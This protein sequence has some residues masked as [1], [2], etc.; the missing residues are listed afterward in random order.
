M[1]ITGT[2]FEMNQL[3]PVCNVG[4]PSVLICF[5][6]PDGYHRVK[7]VEGVKLNCFSKGLNDVIPNLNSN[8]GCF[9]FPFGKNSDFERSYFCFTGCHLDIKLSILIFERIHPT[10]YTLMVY[11]LLRRT[12]P[13]WRHARLT[14]GKSWTY[15]L[16][17]IASSGGR[18]SSHFLFILQHSGRVTP[19]HVSC[20]RLFFG[21]RPFSTVS[22]QKQT[23][24]RMFPSLFLLDFKYPQNHI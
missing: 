11:T 19:G 1:Y 7:P 12:L 22:I 4:L 13:H 20:F 8:F 3:D 5:D 18:G 21:L 17:G 16:H 6:P 9:Q 15:P 10:I 2:G 14:L 23:L 24:L